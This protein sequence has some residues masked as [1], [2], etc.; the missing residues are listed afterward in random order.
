MGSGLWVP[1]AHR[2][3]G[4]DVDQRAE[5]ADLAVRQ[6]FGPEHS[7]S[8]ILFTGRVKAWTLVQIKADLVY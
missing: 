8:G 6:S 7:G 3:P 5:P 1:F 4:R 2:A